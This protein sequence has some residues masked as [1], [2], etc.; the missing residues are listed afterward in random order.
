M[1]MDLEESITDFLNYCL[2][3]KGLSDNTYLSFEYV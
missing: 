1:K 2:I 3:D